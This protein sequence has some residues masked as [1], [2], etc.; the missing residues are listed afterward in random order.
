MGASDASEPSAG[1]SGKARC[2]VQR[3]GLV[4]ADTLR[5]RM[6]V[7]GVLGDVPTAYCLCGGSGPEGPRPR[8]GA[9]AQV[10]NHTTLTRLIDDIDSDR[11]CETTLGSLCEQVIATGKALALPCPSGAFEYHGYPLHL[12]ARG[13]LIST[14]CLVAGRP[15]ADAALSAAALARRYGLSQAAVTHALTATAD[16]VAHERAETVGRLAEALAYD[17]SQQISQDW[18]LLRGGGHAAR[19]GGE[20]EPAPGSTEA[21]KLELVERRLQLLEIVDAMVEGLLVTDPEGVV[22]LTNP[23]ARFLFDA[24]VGD[25]EGR[26]I[27]DLFAGDPRFAQSWG[28]IRSGEQVRIQRELRLHGLRSFD[29]EVSVTRMAGQGPLSSGCVVTV[30]DVTRLV[31]LAS[32]RDAFISNVK[33]EM[34]TPLTTLRGFAHTL[35]EYP[36]IEAEQREEFLRYIEQEAERL[37]RLIEDMLTVARLDVDRSKP[38]CVEFDLGDHVRELQVAFAERCR[39]QKVSLHVSMPDHPVP[40]VADPAL[41]RQLGHNLVGNAL[42]FTPVGGILHIG[43]EHSG[44]V[45][46]LRVVDTGRGIPPEKL[47]RVFE[48]FY[49]EPPVTGGEHG[50]GLGLAIVKGIVDA[51][52]W[53]L[54]IRSEVGRGTDIWVT[55]RTEGVG[56]PRPPLKS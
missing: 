56:S 35:L 33:H 41:L 14:G 30:K 3:D 1:V 31:E 5:R 23:P 51:H 37:G 9:P 53:H 40:I 13:E 7:L 10:T 54:G 45:A 22:L 8:R 17:L 15:R 27:L 43:L 26:H 52:G 42:K 48:K 20:A 24:E 16:P 11:P 36:S 4:D 6:S 2:A 25:L 21:L 18:L 12:R 19:P 39:D 32:L 28:E 49:R 46:S 50:T 29:L 44:E 47:D 38:H 34:R 55:I